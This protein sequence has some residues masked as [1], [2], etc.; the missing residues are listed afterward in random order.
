MKK[1][2]KALKKFVKELF[3]KH[4]KVDKREFN[5]KSVPVEEYLNQCNLD[6]ESF[7]SKSDSFGNDVFS[8]KLNTPAELLEGSTEEIKEM[9]WKYLHS[10]YIYAFYDTNTKNEVEAFLQKYGRA[11]VPSYVS[12]EWQRIGKIYKIVYGASSESRNTELV[13]QMKPSPGGGNVI[14]NLASE[15]AGD[16]QNDE[17]FASLL[18]SN[19]AKGASPQNIMQNLL[20]GNN[21]EL[22]QKMFTKVSTKL[23]DKI[24]TNE[25]NEA[26]IVNQA[27]SMLGNMQ[28]N[29]MMSAMMESMMASGLKHPTNKK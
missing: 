23:N 20:S 26:D 2:H 24:N 29:P 28:N 25:L 21:P 6:F 19:Q 4:P 22:L 1:F 9:V 15:I 11:E 16:L 14:H 18:Q 3:K 27:Q 5:V 17:T 7:E 10:M 13:S 12:E 8:G